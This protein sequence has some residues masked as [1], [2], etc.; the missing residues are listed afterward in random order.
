[1]NSENLALYVAELRRRRPPWLHGYPS[2]LSLL[3]AYLLEQNIDLEYK[4]RWITTG[5]ENLLPQQA[6]LIMHAFGQRP[7]QHYGMAEA[8]ANISECEFGA[9]H[10]DEDFA[11]VE[12]IPSSAGPDCKII[13][14]N[15]TNL[16]TPLLRYDVQDIAT[17]SNNRCACGRTG[18]IVESLDGRLDDYV[19]LRNGAYV[20]RMDHIF[21]DLVN[22]REA[23]IVQNEPGVVLLRIVPRAS[24]TA[25]DEELLRKETTKRL[26]A[27]TT[28]FIE[29]VENLPRSSTGKLR[30][31]E[32]KL[33][34]GK[35]EIPT[36]SISERT[37]LHDDAPFQE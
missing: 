20:G 15:F 5:A 2:L 33:L 25:V 28:I 1:M 21:K 13:G 11:A 9:L 16:A 26:G 3:A 36:K 17:L 37:G 23:Q 29:Y 18:R 30:F 12:F 10:V 6:D 35:L 8:V 34:Q 24:Y 19:I 31:V 32:S 14:T 4:V 7:R 27:E 22:I